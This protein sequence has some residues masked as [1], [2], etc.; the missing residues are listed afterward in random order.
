MT[1]MGTP[2]YIYT[3]ITLSLVALGLALFHAYRVSHAYRM[4]HD[5]RAAVALVKGMGLL[6][7]AI[8]LTISSLGLVADSETMGIAGMS[9]ARGAFIVLLGVLVLVDVR[10]AS[11]P[12]P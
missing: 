4:F 8:G 1:E 3:A 2:E 11:G 7:I 5:E 9:V 10:P 6:V 12:Q